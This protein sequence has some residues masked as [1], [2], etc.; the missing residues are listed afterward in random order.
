MHDEMLI[1]L[2]NYYDEY[3]KISELLTYEE[4]V[5]DSKLCQKLQR[6]Q[7]VL[8]PII[9]IY[10]EY[11]KQTKEIDEYNELLNTCS[12]SEKPQIVEEIRLISENISILETK[13][14]YAINTLN[15]SIEKVTIEI[16]KKDN[17]ISPIII[18]G[19]IE[20]CKAHNL[21][22][23][24]ESADNFEVIHIIGP[25]VKKLFEKE[26]GNHTSGTNIVAQ[27]FVYDRLDESKFTFDEKDI[28]ISI[29]RSSGAGGQHINTTDS[30]IKTTHLPTGITAVCQSERSQIQNREK[31]FINLKEKVE[32]YYSKL[33]TE[34]IKNAKKEQL[35]LINSNHIA[36]NY[37]YEKGI[38]IKNKEKISLK[39]F[40]NG[41]CL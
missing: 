39:D 20:Y 29:C 15:A 26:I 10:Q 23:S 41:K 1:K 30:A 19:Y 40:L 5:L 24:R 9:T 22:Y 17:L 13:L 27:V 8:E 35:K 32:E 11:K 25:N 3:L 33:K 16:I 28:K 38:I 31:A 7:R 21:Q 18:N 37:D 12:E 36:K 14:D 6:E 34:Y 2:N 4:V